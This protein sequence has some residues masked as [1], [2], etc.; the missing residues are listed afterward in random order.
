MKKYNKRELFARIGLL[1]KETQRY[2]F[3]LLC[4]KF[5]NYP[6][7]FDENSKIIELED[8]GLIYKAI[9]KE[10]FKEFTNLELESILY[11]FEKSIDYEE[12]KEQLIEKIFKYSKKFSEYYFPILNFNLQRIVFDFLCKKLNIEFID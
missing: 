10:D 7:K 3:D 1:S 11:V 12:T 5:K 2:L 6:I 4:H 8:C 9:Q